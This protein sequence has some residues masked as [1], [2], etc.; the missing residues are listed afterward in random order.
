[1]GESFASDSERIRGK[2]ADAA[3]TAGARESGA[4]PGFGQMQPGMRRRLLGLNIEGR[5]RVAQNGL[6]P[7]QFLAL[8]FDDPRRGPIFQQIGGDQR[9]ERADAPA[10]DP[11]RRRD[12]AQNRAWRDHE[13]I[14]KAGRDAFR[15]AADMDG[16]FGLQGRERRNDA[17]EQRTV[18]IVL[19]DQHVVATRDRRKRAAALFA[20]RDRRRIVQAGHEENRAR[21][22]SRAGRLESV[23]PHALAVDRQPAQVEPLRSAQRADA[24]IGDGIGQDDV[25]ALRQGAQHAGKAMLGAVGQDD[26]AGVAVARDAV[27]P[28]GDRGARP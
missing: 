3:L 25:A 18:N 26:A 14:A 22:Q 4:S 6:P 20:Q 21:A 7:A 2:H 9:R 23:R 10:I 17:I 15:Q 5:E 19:D 8:E 1:M 16:Q 13:A 27:E 28:I 12:I 24:L 11:Q